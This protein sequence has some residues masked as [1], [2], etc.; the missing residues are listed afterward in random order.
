MFDSM[1]SPIL[2]Y[3]SVVY[4][5]ENGSMIELIFLQFYKIIL[6]FKKSPSKTYYIVNWAIFLQIY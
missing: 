4:G 3:G 6:Q 1:V 5:F 2:L